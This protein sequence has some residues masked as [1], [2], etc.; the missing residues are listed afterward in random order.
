MKLQE[1]KHNFGMNTASFL[2][3]WTAGSTKAILLLSSSVKND[4]KKT[5]TQDTYK[6]Y[7]GWKFNDEES[8]ADVFGNSHPNLRKGAKVSVKLDSPHSWTK[9]KSEAIKFANPKYDSLD[10]KW[11]DSDDLDDMGYEYGDLIGIGILVSAELKK[12]EVVADL[13]N[14]DSNL[15]QYSGEEK[16][17]ITDKGEF[18][19][20]IIDVQVYHHSKELDSEEDDW[21]ESKW[22]EHNKESATEN[23]LMNEMKDKIS[24]LLKKHNLKATEND[25]IKLMDIEGKSSVVIGI[26][27]KYGHEFPFLQDYALKNENKFEK[28][29]KHFDI[30]IIIIILRQMQTLKKG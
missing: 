15:L 7:R 19:V 11:V 14:I 27:M 13:D 2:A 3:K 5:V 30:K 29:Y 1:I 18:S 12:E 9:D 20:E 4:L 10:Q 21:D 16:E 17:I 26:L 24:G 25:L 22:E 6:V 28:S 8:V 23:E